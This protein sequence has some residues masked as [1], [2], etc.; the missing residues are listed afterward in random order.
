MEGISTRQTQILKAI[1][2]EYIE[3]A[4][5]VGSETIEKKYDLGVSPA[6]IRNDMVALTKQG[7]L[8]KPH[9]SA[10]RTPTP[11]ALKFYVDQL[12]EEKKM[13]LTDEVKAKEE[14]WDVRNNLDALMEEATQALAER[15]G[16]LAIGAID[17][18]DKFWH[19]GYS[20]IFQN[21]EFSDIALCENLFS[22][23]EEA[24]RLN[25]LF[26][27]RGTASSVEVLFGEELGWQEL[28]PIG[29]V[30]TRFR[31]RDKDAALG[32]VGPYRLSYPRI[33]PIVKYFGNMISEI[34]ER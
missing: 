20:N 6:T 7:F 15:T 16:N 10:G 18:E 13:S 1:I 9:S 27:G 31:V 32:V 8:Q 14:V 12:M 25:Q 33:I 22:M 24:E 21:P 5:P 26:F 28:S 2:E 17:E 4:M 29:V 3:T 23:L 11:R 19:S 30:T 34:A